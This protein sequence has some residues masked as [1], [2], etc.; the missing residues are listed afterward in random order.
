MTLSF[1]FYLHLLVDLASKLPIAQTKAVNIVLSAGANGTILVSNRIGI[2]LWLGT[3]QYF[4]TPVFYDH[5]I[6]LIPGYQLFGMVQ[7]IEWK[8]SSYL[9]VAA[10]KY[11]TLCTDSCTSLSLVQEYLD[12]A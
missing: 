11:I 6:D 2:W 12:L 4:A 1:K 7:V 10:L 9:K 5:P 3:T 8:R